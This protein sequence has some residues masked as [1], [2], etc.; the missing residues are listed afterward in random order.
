MT[1]Q[2]LLDKKTIVPYSDPYEWAE[3]SGYKIRCLNHLENPNKSVKTTRFSDFPAMEAAIQL[4]EDLEKKSA[5]AIEASNISV[6]VWN[7]GGSE[8]HRRHYRYF[9]ISS[10]GNLLGEPPDSDY[11]W[12]RY[13]PI[14]QEDT[15]GKYKINL[16]GS[17]ECLT[18]EQRHRFAAG[19]LHFGHWVADTLPLF[20]V[21]DQEAELTPY[22]STKLSDTSKQILYS[23]AAD[24]ASLLTELDMGMAHTKVINFSKLVLYANIGVR[25]KNSLLR[26][27]VHSQ[28]HSNNIRNRSSSHR[29]ACYL[30]RGNVD[31]VARLKN[32]SQI[33]EYCERRGI[34]VV[35]PRQYPFARHIDLYRSFDI[36]FMLNSSANT[37]FNVLGHAA[38]NL[39]TF[40]P[41]SYKTK[42]RECILASA[43]YLTPRHEC[44]SLNYVE[45]SG[46]NNS[47]SDECEIPLSS[48]I[49][50]VD[51]I[52]D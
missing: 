45:E 16:D 11:H 30:V 14:F 44:I 21:G 40:V 41:Q 26:G 9:L 32:E 19:S 33:I 4:V 12:L 37:N 6:L 27:V 22:F 25:R 15:P 50:E 24:H 23:F 8:A 47:L 20:L 28:N 49:K 17:C 51:S 43:I 10:D 13:F 46:V 1:R 34:L 31:G 52:C 36:F 42:N 39:I 48:F 38:S 2:I 7:W 35:D 18:V 5:I 29:V 3:N